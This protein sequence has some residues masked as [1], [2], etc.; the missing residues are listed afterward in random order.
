MT[1]FSNEALALQEKNKNRRS[2]TFLL[3]DTSTKPTEKV[4]QTLRKQ[5]R[6]G[7]KQQI[8]RIVEKSIRNIA[9][10]LLVKKVLKLFRKIFPN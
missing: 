8:S 10:L 7:E 3:Q 9:L 2:T 1:F 6:R 5:Q 4:G